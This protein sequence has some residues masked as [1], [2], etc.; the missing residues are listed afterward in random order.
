MK[1]PVH[2]SPRD[3]EIISDVRGLELELPLVKSVHG[4]FH[5]DDG[6]VE[7]KR[8]CAVLTRGTS[9]SPTTNT[10]T[11]NRTDNSGNAKKFEHERGSLVQQCKANIF[12][13]LCEWNH[14]KVLHSCTDKMLLHAFLNLEVCCVCVG[15]LIL[16]LNAMVLG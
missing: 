13:W 9:D 15:D 11:F 3:K 4:E 8:P 5:T 10:D 2:N 6:R 14:L 16:N 12:L 1:P 7:W